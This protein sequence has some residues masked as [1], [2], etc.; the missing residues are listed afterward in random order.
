MDTYQAITKEITDFHSGMQGDPHHRFRSWE[1]CYSFFQSKPQDYD[2]ASLH[3]AFYLASWGMYRG[4]SFLLQKDYLIHHDVVKEI[5]KPKYQKLSDISFVDFS[6][7][8]KDEIIGDLFELID[9][10]KGWYKNNTTTK[11]GDINVTDT[12]ATKILMGTLG[13]T[14][15]YDSYFKIGLKEHNLT[16]SYLNKNNFSDLISFCLEYQQAFEQA[17]KNVSQYGVRYPIMKVIDIY[18]WHLGKSHGKG[19]EG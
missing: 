19:D 1:H 5:L 10:V 14:P 6:S 2:L 8:K 12:L 13:C 4:S 3:L 15:A 16:F 18:F 17:Q 11:R 7:D 9:W